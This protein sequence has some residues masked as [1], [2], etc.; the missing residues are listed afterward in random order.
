M[1]YRTKFIDGVEYIFSPYTRRWCRITTKPD[2]EAKPTARARR[3]AGNPYSRL[4]LQSFAA[5]IKASRSQKAFV[6]AWLQYEAWRSKGA[7]VDLTNS[8]LGFYGVN[9]EMKRRAIRQYER[10]GLITVERRGREAV[11]VTIIDP[12]YLHI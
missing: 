1:K 10:A 12:D 8:E 6:W 5:A 3:R 11:T 2:P 7:T 9:R 4:L